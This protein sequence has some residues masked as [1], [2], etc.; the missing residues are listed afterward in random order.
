MRKP[1]NVSDLAEQ[2]RRPGGRCP[3]PFDRCL[4]DA[5]IIKLPIDNACGT[6]AG[7]SLT[8]ITRDPE[9]PA[10]AVHR[11]IGVEWIDGDGSSPVSG[12]SSPRRIEVRR[13]QIIVGSQIWRLRVPARV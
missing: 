10:E 8:E 4:F 3:E 6:R 13:Y 11:M 12:G 2:D 7:V 5:Q 9:P 1:I